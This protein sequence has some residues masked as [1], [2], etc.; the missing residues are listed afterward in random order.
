M[1]QLHA[2]D[3][4]LVIWLKRWDSRLLHWSFGRARSPCWPARWRWWCGV[5]ASVPFFPR[6]FLPP[7]NEGTLT[8]NVLLNPGTSLAESNRIGTLAEQAGGQ[9][10]EVTQVG[11][12]TGRAELDEHAEGV[13][14]TEMDVDLKASDR[15]REQIIADIRARLAA[16]PAVSSV[17]QPISHRLDHLLS[18]VRA[19]I[20]LKIYGD[21]LDT[22]RGLAADMRERLAKIPGVTDLQIEKQVL[23]PQVKIR[24]DYEQAAQ[25]GVAPG[26]LLR[27]LE[28]MIEG[29]RITQV[30]EGNRRFD[31][32][33]RLPEGGAARSALANLLIETPSG[34]VPLSSWPA[35]RTA[36]ARTRSAARTRAA[37][38]CSRPTPMAATCR[39]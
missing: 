34:H 28:Q 31:L 39:R 10:P 24:L 37:A 2:G 18:G 3:S 11:R 30:V 33:V 17:G 32:L 13:H 19:Q 16:L 1:K 21:D 38:L 15:S 9:V 4:P 6:S 26:A 22:L 5:A 20:A 23:I 8:V 25:Y 35:S 27:S 12:R 14:Y 7:F 29:E 36:T